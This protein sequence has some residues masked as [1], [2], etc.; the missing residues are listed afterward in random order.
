M[1]QTWLSAAMPKGSQQPAAPAP[2][3]PKPSSDLVRQRH[4]HATYPHRDTHATHDPRQNKYFKTPGKGFGAAREEMTLFKWSER[5]LNP[6]ARKSVRKYL[7]YLGYITQHSTPKKHLEEW[8]TVQDTVRFTHLCDQGS[9]AKCG[10]LFIEHCFGEGW[11]AHCTW[12]W[13]SF[14][15][16]AFPLSSSRA[17]GLLFGQLNC[18][19]ELNT[20]LFSF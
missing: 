1:P 2:G 3:N 5:S 18:Y 20:F 10:C 12:L 8:P 9:H 13:N 19:N 17:I 14:L 6:Y 11:L 15:Y 7:V 4:S 16:L